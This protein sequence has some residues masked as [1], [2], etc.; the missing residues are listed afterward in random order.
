MARFSPYPLLW[1][2]LECCMTQPLAQSWEPAAR[3]ALQERGVAPCLARRELCR[4]RTA[5]R[6]PAPGVGE[7]GAWAGGGGRKS[8]HGLGMR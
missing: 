1:P 5:W 4:A 8:W 2:P 6:S 3:E 7:R